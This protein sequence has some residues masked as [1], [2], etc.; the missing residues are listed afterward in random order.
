LYPSIFF[1]FCNLHKEAEN[2][3]DPFKCLGEDGE[4]WRLFCQK[5]SCPYRRYQWEVIEICKQR[6]PLL[7]NKFSTE[8]FFRFPFLT[9]I[10]GLGNKS[11]VTLQKISLPDDGRSHSGDKAL[12]GWSMLT[13]DTRCLGPV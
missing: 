2:I 9:G 8:R 1:I 7:P 12:R 5:K 13:A 4:K 3:N 10:P 11:R 6:E